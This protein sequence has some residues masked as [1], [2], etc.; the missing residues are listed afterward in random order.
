MKKVKVL[1]LCTAFVMGL[2][3]VIWLPGSQPLEGRALEPYGCGCHGSYVN[4]YWEGSMHSQSARDPI[5]QAALD[6]ANYNV[7]DSGEWC[8][9]CHAGYAWMEGRAMPA[10]GSS[11]LPEDMEGNH[12]DLCHAMVDPFSARGIS[13]QTGSTLVSTWGNGQFVITDGALDE[14]TGPLWVS[15]PGAHEIYEDAIFH[16]SE[17]CGQCHD[18]SNP[19]NCPGGD[20]GDVQDCF[21]LDRSYSEWKQSWYGAQGDTERCQICHMPYDN[22]RWAGGRPARDCQNHDFIGANTFSTLAVI[23]LYGGDVNSSALLD[24]N[25]LSRLQLQSGNSVDGYDETDVSPH[26][27]DVKIT[28]LAG[29]KF[30]TGWAEGRRMWI[31]VV[32]RD[33]GGAAVYESGVYH[34]ASA[35]LV[36][37]ADIKVYESI[38]GVS[39]LDGCTDATESFNVML[40]DCIIKDNRIPPRGFTNAAF[41]AVRAEPVGYS[42]ADGQYWDTTSYT[43]PWDAVEV[44]FNVYYQTISYEYMDFLTTHP[45]STAGR[46]ANLLN[47]YNNNGKSTPE[48]IGSFNLVFD[49]DQDG[50]GDAWEI[51][52]FGDLTS[53]GT[54]NPDSDSCDN[55]AEYQGQTDPLTSDCGPP[56]CTD[57]DG[58]GYGPEASCLGPDCDNGDENNWVSCGTCVDT[59]PDTWFVGCDAYVTINGPDCDDSVA[60]C[61]DDCTDGDSGPQQLEF[62]RHLRG[63]RARHL[64]R[65]L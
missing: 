6:V 49:T 44:D 3:G 64:V 12:C 18:V 38:S 58:D 42:Y 16:T 33:S 65:R 32:A 9:R 21:P 51:A 26:Q 48:L 8:L 30:P 55:L 7:A 28:N 43:L 37:D 27:V 14:K 36:H 10:D 13:L 2:M 4:D 40:N 53:D 34:G 63:H 25:T 52:Y 24:G 61:T 15:P 57:P 39:G 23:E 29:H 5:F 54:G 17:I 62:L 11:L 1:I 47:T 60:G 20:S 45:G 31:N 46:D 59:E 35:E 56:P 19:N 50:L 22:H 41:A